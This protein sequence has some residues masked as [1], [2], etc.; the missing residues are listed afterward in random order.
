[1]ARS[2]E[3]PDSISLVLVTIKFFEFGNGK[4]GSPF[5][6]TSVASQCERPICVLSGRIDL[7]IP[8]K[9]G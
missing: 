7:T 6:V 3:L 2:V 5:P 8:Q 1:M 4:P 9:G